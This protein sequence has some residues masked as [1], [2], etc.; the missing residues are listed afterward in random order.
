M[1]IIRS[2]SH[3]LLFIGVL[4]QVTCC[5]GQFTVFIDGNVLVSG[6]GT[7][8]TPFKTLDEGIDN[9][10]T[11]QISAQTTVTVNVAQAT[12]NP[13]K[14]LK[15][16]NLLGTLKIEGTGV[17]IVNCNP[18]E[19]TISIKNT[20]VS[21]KNIKITNCAG[22][23]A[24]DIFSANSNNV[25]LINVQVSD[26]SNLSVTPVNIVIADV[27]SQ[28]KF[29]GCS[30]KNNHLERLLPNLAKN[31]NSGMVLVVAQ[32]ATTDVNTLPDVI[33]DNCT[34][35]N[36]I[37]E[38][39]ST[40]GGFVTGYNA[41]IRIQN[42]RVSNVG[43]TRK[44][45]DI[46]SGAIGFTTSG[47]MEVSSCT[48][49]SNY[50]PRASAFVAYDLNISDSVFLNHTA[51]ADGM[52]HIQQFSVAMFQNI[53]INK[54]I[55]NNHVLIYCRRCRSASFID[56]N[57]SDLENLSLGGP[58]IY[59]ST[60]PTFNQSLTISGTTIDGFS[61]Q[62]DMGFFQIDS[63]TNADV[64][65]VVL[66]KSVFRN[67]VVS[68]G[69]FV[70]LYKLVYNINISNSLFEN[71]QSKL[72][73]G[74][75]A[76][77]QSFTDFAYIKM[78]NVTVINN[79]GA[80]LINYAVNGTVD[81]KNCNFAKNKLGSPAIFL[82]MPKDY[83]ASVVIDNSTFTSN[84]GVS[85][86]DLSGFNIIGD[87]KNNHFK[88]NTRMDKGAL[89]ISASNSEINVTS[90]E[91]ESNEANFGAAITFT[92]TSIGWVYVAGGRNKLS[93]QSNTFKNNIGGYGGAIFA[94][95]SG[96][97]KTILSGNKFGNNTGRT[98]GGVYYFPR[99]YL[100]PPSLLT[101]QDDTLI[102]GLPNSAPYGALLA[103]DP[104]DITIVSNF[105]NGISA[106]S[107][108]YLP[109]IIINLVDEFG[110]KVVTATENIL[111][112]SMIL[113]SGNFPTANRSS[114]IISGGLGLIFKSLEGK[115]IIRGQVFGNPGTYQIDVNPTATQFAILK[116]R[117]SIQNLTIT[118]CPPG[119]VNSSVDGTQFK[120]C[121]VPK[122]DNGCA[123]GV[124]VDNNI[125]S[126]ASGYIGATCNAYNVYHVS[127]TITSS[128]QILGI[129]FLAILVLL[130]LILVIAGR[131]ATSF[132]QADKIL[133][134]G[135]FCGISTNYNYK[136]ANLFMFQ[137]CAISFISLIILDA[138]ESGFSCIRTPILQRISFVLVFTT[139]AHHTN[140]LLSAPNTN[141]DSESVQ[142]KKEVN[143][144]RRLYL[145]LG[146]LTIYAALVIAWLVISSASP[147]F[148]YLSNGSFYL[149]CQGSQLPFAILCA[150]L[151]IL[152]VGAYWSLPYWDRTG[153]HKETR[154]ALIGLYNWIIAGPILNV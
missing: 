63:N 118:D 91:F 21:I 69:L 26:N 44:A 59:M 89:K 96:F 141:D 9:V 95:L 22:F 132:L 6:D 23:P 28:V 18:T 127:G 150:E 53:T 61:A 153:V 109:D 71:I 4:L 139:V 43:I 77:M 46:A 146:M 15:L 114:A 129:V 143:A 27:T 19:P 85:Q 123:H 115:C 54:S 86:V 49:E 78:D 121:K 83:S 154:F 75:I 68:S 88:Y 7:A 33:F 31:E 122:C 42:S 45:S 56:C 97:E 117:H 57:I 8:G 120:V 144:K 72:T 35:E 116:T 110:Q 24:I 111:Q 62:S 92:P 16:H 151:C 20:I 25:D 51:Y 147:T 12:Y 29:T 106:Y 36:L 79:R 40:S 82:N 125:C 41:Y 133:L 32:H 113:M 70:S 148:Q 1:A 81:I 135:I 73:Y 58:A 94:D 48:F 137:G 14:S 87:I 5:L 13:N 126:C 107:G 38:T 50:S 55:S 10:N 128:S 112:N 65:D 105:T 80:G 47:K 140:K 52:F 17:P 37:L 108:A 84:N 101:N 149:A 134:G 102:P 152:S 131:K 30:F 90:N 104:F 142:G 138:S 98:A 124:C 2:K 3:L 39:Y 74:S 66:D 76:N 119:L 103:S 60:D 100:C 93:L 11:M 34:G 99:S 64:I 136:K 130:A 145:I 67:F